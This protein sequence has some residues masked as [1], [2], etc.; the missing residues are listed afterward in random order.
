MAIRDEKLTLLFIVKNKQ[1]YL[2]KYFTV[3]IKFRPTPTAETSR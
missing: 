3:N 1:D 2:F